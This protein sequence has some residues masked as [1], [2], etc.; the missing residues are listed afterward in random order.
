MT[1]KKMLTFHIGWAHRDLNVI[2][3][4]VASESRERSLS[5]LVSWLLL[6]L[7]PVLLDSIKSDTDSCCL[8]DCLLSPCV[9]DLSREL[10]KSMSPDDDPDSDCS[11]LVAVSNRRLASINLFKVSGPVGPTGATAPAAIAMG[12]SM[13]DCRLTGTTVPCADN[14]LCRGAVLTSGSVGGGAG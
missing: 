2:G 11:L 5:L 1:P 14:G 4:V 9:G 6:L 13:T 7:L 10:L 3:A 12:E 8:A